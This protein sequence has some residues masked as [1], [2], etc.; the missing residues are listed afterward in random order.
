MA[1]TFRSMNDVPRDGTVVEI[2]CSYGVMPHYDIYR[3]EDE[4]WK[5][6]SRP[7]HGLASE[8]QCN[9]RPYSGDATNYVDPTGGAQ[10]TN[11]YWHAGM[12]H[13]RR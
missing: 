11:E 8:A 7:G 2:E 6:A 1:G 5:S 9:W 10:W 13:R 3:W 4:S 12:G